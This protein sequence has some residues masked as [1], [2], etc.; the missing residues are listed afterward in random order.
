M[1]EEHTRK[2]TGAITASTPA[3]RRG[4]H[5]CN[6]SQPTWL[7]R[8]EKARGKDKGRKLPDLLIAVPFLVRPP[9]FRAFPSI[10]LT[11]F[12]LWLLGV[13]KISAAI[14]LKQLICLPLSSSLRSGGNRSHGCNLIRYQ[15]AADHQ[16]LAFE[17]MFRGIGSLA[18]WGLYR[19]KKR[20]KLCS[21]SIP[22]RILYERTQLHSLCF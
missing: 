14:R 22:R 10:N 4:L 7:W 11:D 8:A 18:F 9:C 3:S 21:R 1:R 16:D 12:R 17:T 2:N 5:A 15:A 19:E 6:T 20:R 13:L